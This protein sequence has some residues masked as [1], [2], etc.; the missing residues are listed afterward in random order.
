MKCEVAG[1]HAGTEQ[2]VSLTWSREA[3]RWPAW[4]AP[5]TFKGCSRPG[6]WLL[7]HESFQKHREVL[8]VTEGEK[9]S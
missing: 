7:D 2:H 4:D 8:A 1:S 6:I 3:A 5:G 9:T